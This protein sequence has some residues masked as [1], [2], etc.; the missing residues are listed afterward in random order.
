MG[1]N[2][3]L[4]LKINITFYYRIYDITCFLYFTSCWYNIQECV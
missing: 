4:S 3:H 2:T 1:Y